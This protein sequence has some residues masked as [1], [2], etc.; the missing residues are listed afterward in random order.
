MYLERVEKRKIVIEIQIHI[1]KLN[2]AEIGNEILMGYWT[3]N[4]SSFG[5]RKFAVENFRSLRKLN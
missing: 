1:N 3:L 5:K 2:R 4:V